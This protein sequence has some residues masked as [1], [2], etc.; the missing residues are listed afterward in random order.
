MERCLRRPEP[1]QR[2]ASIAQWTAPARFLWF[3]PGR[4]AELAEGDYF[5]EEGT[6]FV[7]ASGFEEAGALGFISEG[8]AGWER[9]RTKSTSCQRWSWVRRFLKEG[10]GFL[11]SLIW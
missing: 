11:P 1:G 3:C 9:E 7:F 10:M 2:I 4:N 6:G 8:V 5:F